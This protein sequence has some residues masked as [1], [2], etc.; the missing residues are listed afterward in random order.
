V[1]VLDETGHV[2]GIVS[3]GDLMR[4]NETGTA[5]RA[6]PWLSLLA[7]PA[8]AA[9]DYAK[10]H[11]RT[12]GDVMTREVIGV[13]ENTP[14]ADV[15]ALL[16]RHHIKRAPVLRGGKLVGIV[17]RANLVQGLATNSTARS[18]AS[19]DPALRARILAEL[20]DAGLDAPRV[21]VIVTQGRVSLWGLVDSEDE[22][23]AIRIVAE[24]AAGATA[25]EDH[26]NVLSAMLRGS[27]PA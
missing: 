10:S 20:R 18:T 6:S 14:L 24:N 5:R 27:W 19:D 4:R 13:D 12:A 26:L 3:E 1:P 11:G 7:T 2:V 21:N 16:E 23:R 15:A 8:Q 9:R 22:K 25:V 17:S